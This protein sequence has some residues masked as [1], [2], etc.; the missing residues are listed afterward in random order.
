MVERCQL[1]KTMSITVLVIED[2]LS[3]KHVAVL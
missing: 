3:G 2:N 1:D